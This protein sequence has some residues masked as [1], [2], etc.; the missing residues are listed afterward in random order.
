[1]TTTVAIKEDT[2]FMLS[3][4]KKEFEASN[5]DETI[6]QMIGKIKKLREEG[7]KDIIIDEKI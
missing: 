7:I 4:M 2:Y 6:K 5:F 1:M 3:Q